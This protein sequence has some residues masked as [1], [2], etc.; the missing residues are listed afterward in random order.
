[1]QTARVSSGLAAITV[2][3]ESAIEVAE[4]ASVTM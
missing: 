2:P 1:M 4:A 3:G